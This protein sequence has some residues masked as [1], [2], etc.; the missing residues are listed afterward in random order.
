MGI[1]E[2][3][4]LVEQVREL[5]RA[6]GDGARDL[7]LGLVRLAQAVGGP[8]HVLDRRRAQGGQ[9]LEGADRG[10]VLAL[11]RRSRQ[12]ALD[13]VEVPVLAVEGVHDFARAVVV[14]E[15]R[16]EGGHDLRLH[17][18]RGLVRLLALE[19]RLAQAVLARDEILQAEDRGQPV[20]QL[21]RPLVEHR[22]ELVVAEAGPVAAQ[23]LVPSEGRR[24]HPFLA[25]DLGRAAPGLQGVALLPGQH[26]RAGLGFALEREL[27]LDGGVRMMEVAPA[28][29][30]D[31]GAVEPA[32][33]LAGEEQLEPFREAGLA[34]PVAAD[35]E[36]QPG[37][38]GQL[39]ADLLPH[40]AEALD[41]DGAQVRDLGL[42]G[43]GALRRL[44]LA[45][46]SGGL[47]LLWDRARFDRVRQR[48]VALERGQH[49]QLPG[50][51][52]AGGN[53]VELV[54]DARGEAGIGRHEAI[55]T[56]LPRPDIPPRRGSSRTV[57]RPRRSGGRGSC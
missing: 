46:R 19:A 48:V 23:R 54:E 32:V 18:G 25:A 43:D 22:A 39:E 9:A 37:S 4:G 50:V 56:G 3:E 42:G 44:G 51:V 53:L 57:D 10:L 55:Y 11:S 7:A 36:G 5:T 8:G 20:V 52:L 12:H 27:G 45:L 33:G 16:A 35:D 31:L 26:E 13:L 29:L 40:S 1:V 49:E 47:P 38:R 41:G 24:V 15:G 28:V 2:R 34:G 14:G 17:L 30:P 6:A 21:G